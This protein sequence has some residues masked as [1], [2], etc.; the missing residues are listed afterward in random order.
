MLK[1][2]IAIFCVLSLCLTAA[3]SIHR[4]NIQQGNVIDESMVKQLHLGMTK[5]QV[6]FIMGTPLLAD[7][8]HPERW[9]Y[10]YYMRKDNKITRHYRMSLYFDNDKLSK[11][12]KNNADAIK[13][14]QDVQ[15]GD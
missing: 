12:V 11:I 8:F 6:R 14:P 4:I 10:V 13:G 5:R 1:R 3:C 9:D 7:P 2:L 15:A